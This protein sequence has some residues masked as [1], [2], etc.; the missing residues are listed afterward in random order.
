MESTPSDDARDFDALIERLGRDP[1]EIWLALEGLSRLEP[2]ERETIVAELER[3]RANPAAASLLRLLGSSPEP[4]TEWREV[5]SESASDMPHALERPIMASCYVSPV[6]GEGRAVVAV[7]TRHGGSRKTA[8]FLCDVQRG[9]Q[10]VRGEIE[11]DSAD[12]GGLIDAIRP[13]DDLTGI[14]DDVELTLGLLA[15]GLELA[16]E[17]VSPSVRRWIVETVG[18]QFRPAR[19]PA[20]LLETAPSLES[21]VE[22]AERTAEVLDACPSWYDGSTLTRELAGELL[23]RHGAVPP[24]PARDAGAYR[25]LFERRLSGRLELYRSMLLWMA[26]V[27]GR[28]SEGR[29]AHSALL[30]AGQL[31]DEQFAVPSHP[32][33]SA[34]ATRGLERAQAALIAV[35]RERK[36]SEPR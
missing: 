36:A 26:L 18:P 35:G 4:R 33:V 17:G 19:F 27:W 10:D 32:F 22:I 1:G 5:L 25:F 15:A 30:L 20:H 2:G 29:L 34:L 9:I 16:D 28:S 24:D 13:G 21:E 11:V 8:A 14:D 3:R 7:S 12:A 31:M 6:D 23:F